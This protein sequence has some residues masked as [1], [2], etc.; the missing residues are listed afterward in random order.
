MM[1]VEREADIMVSS[2]QFMVLGIEPGL[3]H[4]PDKHVAT[5]FITANCGFYFELELKA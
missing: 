3:L 1:C 4:L 2:V 5:E